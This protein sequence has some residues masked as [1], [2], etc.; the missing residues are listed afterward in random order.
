MLRFVASMSATMLALKVVDVARDQRLRQTL[1][2][3]TYLGFLFNPFTL[4]RR[5]LVFEHRP[6]QRENFLRFFM[7]ATVCF[8][9]T[10]AHFAL[11]RVDWVGIPF[12]VEHVSKVASL[13]GAIVAGLMAAAA[14]WRLSGGVARDFMD[15]PFLAPT[16][17]VFWRRYNRVVQ[18][19]FWENLFAGKRAR[20]APLRAMFLVFLL[21]GLLHEWVFYAA[22]GRFQ[23]YQMLFFV[24]QGAAAAATARV[25]VRGS[26]MPWVVGTLAFNLLTSVIFFASIHNVVPFYSRGLPSWLQ[27]W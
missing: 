16:P 6:P 20:R 8:A 12:L 24:L 19:F 5:R 2:W 22:I 15:R 7:G 11:F 27:T 13:M 25:R 14:A 10:W 23:G 26:A 1:S 17:A 21:S 9:A 4:V 18:Q 3:R